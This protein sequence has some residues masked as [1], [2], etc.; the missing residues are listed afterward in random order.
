MSFK[1]YR[2]T[3]LIILILILAT[4]IDWL[5]LKIAPYLHDHIVRAPSNAAI[6]TLFLAAYDKWLWK[7][8]ILRLLVTVPNLNGRY[9]GSLSSSYNGNSIEKECVIEIFQ[10][11]SK[12]TIYLFANNE[13]KERSYSK[14]VSE[15]IH[16]DEDNEH[17]LL[18][19]YYNY[20][21]DDKKLSSHE[22]FNH[23]KVIRKKKNTIK[24]KGHYF[25]NREPQTRGE[26]SVKFES[27]IRKKRF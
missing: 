21:L 11:A 23:L 19:T 16:D 13:Q 27:N 26:I 15:V 6:I 1:H 20:G 9:R 25:T 18:F 5:F 7:F 10:T 24:L 2:A 4:A 12:T 8:P 17:Q 3:P 22:G 14:S